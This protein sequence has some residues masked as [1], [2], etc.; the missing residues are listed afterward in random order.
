MFRWNVTRDPLWSEFNRLDRRMNDLLYSLT[1]SR[2]PLS[3]Q[4]W[5]PGRIFPLL[6]VRK[7]ENSYVVMAE[8]PG[9]K[10]E[11]LEI[12]VEGDTVSLKGERKVEDPEP[13][14]SY[15]R[16]ERTSGTFQRSL[17]LPTRVETDQVKANYQNGV[18][19]VT[20]PMEKA[21][22]PKQITVNVD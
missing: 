14:A 11:D 16:K 18:L 12:K 19:T 10:T 21:V 20:L 6:N 3:G 1:G 9:L 15:H 2:R 4:V 8:I 5:S 7:V 13:G 22:E 17:T